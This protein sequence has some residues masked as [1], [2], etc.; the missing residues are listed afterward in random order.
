MAGRDNLGRGARV[1]AACLAGIWIAGGSLGLV[2]GL[3]LRQGPVPVLLGL[4]GIGYGW[5]WARVALTGERQHW[6]LR[7]RPRG[8]HLR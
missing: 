5:V 1:I 7:R 4:L 8:R 3:K 2:I 6:G